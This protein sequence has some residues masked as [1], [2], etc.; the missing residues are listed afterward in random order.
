MK[1][2]TK[3]ELPGGCFA[4]VSDAV[5][6]QPFPGMDL[7]CCQN[8]FYDICSYALFII[9][10]IPVCCGNLHYIFPSQE[11]SSFSACRR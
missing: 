7:M 2:K 8:I 4:G 3:T 5:V 6:L 10:D 1:Q 9:A 11:T